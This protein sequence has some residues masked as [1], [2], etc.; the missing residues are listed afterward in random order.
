[1][2]AV[3]PELSRGDWIF[4]EDRGT[5]CVPGQSWRS[6]DAH[7]DPRERRVVNRRGVFIAARYESYLAGSVDLLRSDEDRRRRVRAVDSQLDESESNASWRRHIEQSVAEL[8]E[9]VSRLLQQQTGSS[10]AS[11][12]TRDVPSFAPSTSSGGPR[13]F[14]RRSTQGQG[15]RRCFKCGAPDHIARDCDSA[16]TPKAGLQSASSLRGIQ[17]DVSGSEVYLSARLYQGSKVISVDVTLDSG[18][19]YS[20]LP[21]KYV[22]KSNVQRTDVRLVAAN[23]SDISVLGQAR[24][25]FAIGGIKLTADVLVSSAVDEWL[26]GF[27]FLS[28]NQ[29][30]WNFATSTITIRGHDVQLR[31]RRVLNHVR[32]VIASDNVIIP[33]R[34]TAFVPVK[35]AFTNLHTRP[36]NWL[37]EPRLV[38]D[39]LLMARG[40]FGDGEDSVVRLV[41][42]T[43]RDVIVKRDHC[44]GNA[45]P[46]NFQC[47]VCGDVCACV[48]NAQCEAAPKVRV[49]NV[50]PAAGK[51]NLPAAEGVDTRADAGAVTTVLSDDEVIIPMLQSLPDCV[52]DT[53]RVE[54]EAV[55]RKNVN[56]FSRHEY[57]V[58]LTD[59]VQY[60]LELKDP[61]T[62]PVCEPLRQHPLAY[63][64]LIDSE[65]DKLL[66]AG[67]IVPTNSTWASN[68]VLVKRKGTPNSPPRMRITVDYRAVN[69]CLHRLVYPMPSTKL[70][71]DCLQ[72]HSHFTTL[73]FSNAYLSVKLDPETSHITAF[74]TRRGMFK[75]LRLCA[76][77]S[78]GTAVFNQ[79]AQSLFSEWLWSEV[80]TFLDDVT[81]PSRTIEEGIQLLSKVLDRLQTAGLKLKESKCKLLQ[82]QVKIL[83]VIVSR[84]SMQ[85]DPERA[86]VVKALEF[87]RTKREMRAFLGYVNFGRS[88]YKNLSE[89]TEPLTACLRKGGQ[90]QQTP[91]T[92]RAFERLKEIMASPP[93]LAMFDPNAKHIVDCDA[94]GY[95][96]GACLIQVGQDGEERTVGYMSKTF[97]DTERRYCTSRQELLA[98]IKSLQYWRNYLIG[99]RV[100]V[101]SD[102]KALQYLLSSKSLSA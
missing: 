93:V 24:V 34:A 65:V 14:N 54:I 52:T 63:L 13:P 102:H 38:S 21:A 78:S 39:S 6:G 47:G 67:L 100:I 73:D 58:G 43:A 53:Q 18:S 87:P 62:K 30:V 22:N 96:C 50:D 85:E 37:I 64:D 98:I 31:R 8:K 74:V 3:G 97:S 29:C 101:R 95:T 71:F 82:T 80:L 9:G 92:L 55:L 70:I 84:D 57:D 45:E 56:L 68:I 25:S 60:K 86:A 12:T 36:S 81:L 66:N 69:S 7:P 72:G 10:Q 44:F 15:A 90:V 35:L 19:F 59:L 77:I 1:V 32:R 28:K 26:L 41:N 16:A 20:V 4:I 51:L 33:S 5:G 91:E 61:Q 75:W 49:L 48:P 42:P 83:G 79:L 76:G 17:T 99:R 46:L 88:F 27:D 40:L 11:A 23:G 94:S 2:P 89:I